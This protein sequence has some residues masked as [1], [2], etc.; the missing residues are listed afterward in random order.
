LEPLS[1]II[2]AGRKK[3][4]NTTMF[5]AGFGVSDQGFFDDYDA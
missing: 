2:R 5:L 1:A 3:S 4:W